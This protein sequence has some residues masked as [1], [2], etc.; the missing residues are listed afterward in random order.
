MKGGRRERKKEGRKERRERSN[1]NV[2]LMLKKLQVQIR[3]RCEKKGK[4]CDIKERKKV[5]RKKG[6]KEVGKQGRSLCSLLLL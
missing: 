6:R 5:G 3:K 4:F 1:L 2:F